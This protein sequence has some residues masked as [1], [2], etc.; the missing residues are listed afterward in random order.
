MKTLISDYKMAVTLQPTFLQNP[1]I[2]KFLVYV[3]TYQHPKQTKLSVVENRR[4]PEMSTQN[5]FKVR[6]FK[7]KCMS[8][9]QLHRRCE[10]HKASSEVCL[11]LG[12]YEVL[13]ANNSGYSKRVTSSPRSIF[14]RQE[15]E[16]VPS[17]R[18]D[19]TESLE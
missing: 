6:N 19:E 17:D 7:S 9:R 16:S 2:E 18:S 10:Q 5:Q 3:N 8:E 12:A 4:N 14:T 11:K 15:A 1:R 13:I